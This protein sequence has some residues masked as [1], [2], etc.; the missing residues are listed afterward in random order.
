[1]NYI[2]LTQ[3]NLEEEH[4]CC[5]ISNNN[6]PQVSS[7]KAWLK[8]RMKE[9]LVFLKADARGKCFIEYIPSEHAWAAI[10]ADGYLYIDCFW[11]S[12]SLKG[13]GYADELLAQC[14]E[15]AK[16]QDKNGI[17]VISSVK[18]QSFLSDPKYL[19]Y[20]GFKIA[21]TADP[22]FTLM[23]LPLKD[24][25][26]V[27]EFLPQVKHPHIQKKGFV[28]Y[29][30][31][32]CPYTAKYVPLVQKAAE[33]AGIAFECIKITSCKEAQDAPA[34]WTSYALFYNGKYVTNEI[35]NEKRFLALAEKLM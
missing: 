5:A 4:I 15:D 11:V 26:P 1:M 17:C 32:G 31:S 8:E 18:K 14:I 2:R 35:Q 33:D 34:A 10:K 13:H 9:G 23:V 30:T 20:K 25:A 7:K 3:E 6:D 19:A 27:P 21:D 16:K 28:L 24:N 22:F 29:Y 12:G